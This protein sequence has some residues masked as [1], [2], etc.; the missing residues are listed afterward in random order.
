[1]IAV[2]IV[3]LVLFVVGALTLFVLAWAEFAQPDDDDRS[4]VS[5]YMTNSEW[6]YCRHHRPSV[7]E[8]R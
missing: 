1:M 6:R 4:P 5:T 8:R 2:V 3:C 7:R